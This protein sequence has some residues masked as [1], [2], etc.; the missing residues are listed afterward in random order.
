MRIRLHLALTVLLACISA[1]GLHAQTTVK[2][3]KKNLTVKEFNVDAGSSAKIIDHLTVYNENGRK[4]EETEYDRMGVKWRKVFEYGTD[5]RLA[6]ELVYG[7]NGKL[8][9]I[10]KFEF[11]ELGRKKIEYVYSAKGKMIR[12]KLFEYTIEEKE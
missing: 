9:N 4:I 8:D 3:H 10:R 1:A 7:A 2:P 5:G 11:D 6:R 12:Y